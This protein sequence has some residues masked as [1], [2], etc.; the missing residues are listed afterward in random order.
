MLCTV[1]GTENKA[2]K[3]DKV[4]PRGDFKLAGRDGLSKV[5]TLEVRPEGREGARHMQT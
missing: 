1:F 3:K 5:V 2:V 4:L